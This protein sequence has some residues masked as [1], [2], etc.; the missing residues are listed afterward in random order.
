ML[1]LYFLKELSVVKEQLL[2]I[3]RLFHEEVKTKARCSYMEGWSQQAGV[4]WPRL[5][6][7]LAEE[8]Y[9]GQPLRKP[10]SP[11]GAKGPQRTEVLLASPASLWAPRMEVTR[12]VWA[13]GFTPQSPVKQP[14]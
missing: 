6:V 8:K 9:S 4:Q 7:C 13:A 14:K 12:S 2:G 1:K 3:K 10:L 11:G 5:C